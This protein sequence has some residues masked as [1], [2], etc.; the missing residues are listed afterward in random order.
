MRV[1]V[2]VGLGLALIV[3]ECGGP[4]GPSEPTPDVGAEVRTAVHEPR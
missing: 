3:S 2:S 1:L 4:G